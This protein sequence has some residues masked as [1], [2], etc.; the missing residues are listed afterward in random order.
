[1][2]QPPTSF[3]AGLARLVLVWILAGLLVN[4]PARFDT[5]FTP[6]HFRLSIEVAAVILLAL[7][8]P[9]GFPVAR[10]SSL[11]RSPA[12]AERWLPGVLLR[13]AAAG[14]AALVLLRGADLVAH[15]AA[16]RPLD[17]GR[18]LY[19]MPALWDV[20]AGDPTRL[21]A[22]LGF[23][24]LPAV[25]V[26]LLARRGQI[27]ARRHLTGGRRPAMT[28]AALGGMLA[29]GQVIGAAS[30]TG[31][32]VGAGAL[33]LAAFQADAL[34]ARAAIEAEL[35]AAVADDPAAGLP[36]P[37]LFPRLRGRDVNLFF[38]ESY[39]WSAHH[40]PRIREATGRRLAH[41]GR[42]L[43]AAGFRVVS[44]WLDSPV[45]GGQSWLA[46]GTLL[47]GL[48]LDRQRAYD[49]AL[50][51]GRTTLVD[52]FGRA[53]WRTVALM[54][55]IRETWPEAA[56]F[57]YDRVMD[58]AALDYRGPAFGWPTVPDQY[59]LDRYATEE[60]ALVDRPPLFLEFAMITSH[61]PW[62]PL[63]PLLDDW[64]M[65]GAAGGRIFETAAPPEDQ[66]FARD[67]ADWAE[68]YANALDYTLALVGRWAVE[69]MPEDALLI[70]V[71][72][73]QPPLVTPAGAPHSVPIHVIARDPGLI[74]AFQAEGLTPGLMLS[75]DAPVRP[76]A[77]W[78]DLMIRATRD[79][80]PP[81]AGLPSD[82]SGDSFENR[83]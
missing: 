7:A 61:H 13:L 39:G 74:R 20:L 71:G 36:G 73:H 67:T 2:R 38:M 58:A 65:A 29:L 51:A 35:A 70:V 78:R 45:V 76:M 52:L 49:Y 1:M 66:P 79:A 10:G 77:V 11:A 59:A 44:G 3:A 53:G 17:L 5:W 41:L 27:L 75:A 22:V 43:D 62:G 8:L 19:L 24:I 12:Q 9:G 34:K 47:S 50:S 26:Y 37:A 68:R 23:W 69:R 25:A 81:V 33:R 14:L 64:S 30:Q 55:A 82:L 18:D 15:A 60:Q 80:A 57:G 48:T 46:H 72:D 32:P 83:S 4:M 28:V 6:A 40:D 31:G 16:G 56:A 63:P 54:P 42:T 21:A